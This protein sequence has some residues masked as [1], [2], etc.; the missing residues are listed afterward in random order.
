[1]QRCWEALP[2]NRPS[3]AD[4]ITE[5]EDIQVQPQNLIAAFKW[6]LFWLVLRIWCCPAAVAGNFRGVEPETK[7]W[8]RVTTK[9]LTFSTYLFAVSRNWSDWLRIQ[10]TNV[11][12]S[13][14]NQLL[15]QFC[16]RFLGPISRSHSSHT[17]LVPFFLHRG[18]E[19][20]LW[21]LGLRL[22]MWIS[23]W[24]SSAARHVNVQAFCI[25]FT[26]TIQA[27]WRI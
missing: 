26:C 12:E 25:C 1:M 7:G 11:G 22:D 9:H 6:I 4:I 27:K 10:A 19:I 5:L 15:A 8:W 2:S 3:F 21:V 20:S 13:I 14:A 17:D 24:E 16:L 23:E 18:E